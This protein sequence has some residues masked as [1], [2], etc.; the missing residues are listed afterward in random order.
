MESDPLVTV[1]CLCYNHEAFVI[2]T[3]DSVLNQTYK[4]IEIILIDDFSTD[5]SVNV[6]EKYL[7][8]KSVSINFIK[9]TTNLGL[10]K[11]FNKAVTYAKGSFLIDLACDDVLLP[12]CIERQIQTYNESNISETAIVFGNAVN[13][14]EEGNFLSYFFEV[15]ENKFV[16]DKVLH[17]T[18][19]TTILNSGKTFCSVSAMLN[20]QIF[21]I[22]GGYDENLAFEDLDYWLRA[23]RKYNIVFIDRPLICKRR[24][25]NSQGSQFHI[26]SS[27]SD[28]MDHSNLL[29]LKKA[30]KMNRN[31]EEHKNLLKR[32]NY[33]LDKSLHAYKWGIAFQYALLKLKCHYKIWNA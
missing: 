16:N 3:I 20:R 32:V 12:D 4:N 25:I 1:I 15:D 7:L 30:L 8:E 23:S 27:F 6:I 17:H 26:K 29:I 13:I 2:K 28:K 19:Y 24:V 21:D 33:S 31:S 10:T 14:S 5:T 22:L 9:N 18:S 11:T